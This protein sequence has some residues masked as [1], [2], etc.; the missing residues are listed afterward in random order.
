MIDEAAMAK[1]ERTTLFEEWRQAE[2]AVLAE[3][4]RMA[5]WAPTVE[6]QFHGSTLGRDAAELARV[7]RVYRRK[8]KAYFGRGPRMRYLKRGRS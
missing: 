4:L 1:E 5:A 7:V 6:D 8:Y 3:A 2:D